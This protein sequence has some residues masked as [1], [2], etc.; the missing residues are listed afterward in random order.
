[1]SDT[2]ICHIDDRAVAWLD[3]MPPYV[4]NFWMGQW[5]GCPAV[6]RTPHIEFM[7]ERS[8]RPQMRIYCSHSNHVHVQVIPSSLGW[9]YM[10][11]RK[12]QETMLKRIVE[13]RFTTRSRSEP[14]VLD[15]MDKDVYPHE[16]FR[17]SCSKSFEEVHSKIVFF[18]RRR[19]EVI[20][21]IREVKGKESSDGDETKKKKTPTK[22]NV[23]ALFMDA[24][25]RKHF[26]RKFPKTIKVMERIQS[27]YEAGGKSNMDTTGIFQFFRYHAV[28]FSTDDNT[29][30]MWTGRGKFGLSKEQI[31]TVFKNT[32]VLP[33]LWHTFK[34]RGYV[35]ARLDNF[36]E[37]WT[38]KYNNY[39]SDNDHE[40]ITP[41]CLPEYLKINGANDIINGPY[42]IRHRCLSGQFVHKYS[43]DYIKKFWDVYPDVPKFLVSAYIEGHELT[44]EIIQD[45]DEDLANFFA[46]MKTSGRLQNTIMVLLSDHGLHC[47]LLPI[48]TRSG[49]I[50]HM[51]PLQYWFIPNKVLNEHKYL[52]ENL[53]LNSQRLVT[54]YDIHETLK[55][56]LD[57]SQVPT[58]HTDY[59]QLPYGRSLFSNSISPMRTC[60]DVHVPPHY[61]KCQYVA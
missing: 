42:G 55:H 52:E 36:C 38:A 57:L 25:S 13:K 27:E 49:M 7:N 4:Q 40:A 48:M 32:T 30:A 39:I 17:V 41:F 46:E 33:P 26:Q 16:S 37:D 34:D 6:Y 9:A 18:P 15:L 29:R 2:S 24:L 22:L 31:E 3:I 11:K 19:P 14:A 20:Q 58:Y 8:N 59:S 50:E 23:I 44:G 21:R 61:C 45:V 12:M 60:A 53:R 35:T 51:N 10:E 1:M 5:F 56:V 43:F 28:D 47:G 54:A